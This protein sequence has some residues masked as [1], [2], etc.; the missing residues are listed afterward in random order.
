[1]PWSASLF[2]L[3][4]S[5]K[6]SQLKYTVEVVCLAILRYLEFNF[7]RDLVQGFLE[8]METSGVEVEIAMEAFVQ[9]QPF[10]ARLRLDM[11]NL[12]ITASLLHLCCDKNPF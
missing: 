4:Y 6:G 8:A 2:L 12:Q 7:K 9:V 1:M 3:W 11:T 10:S 5:A